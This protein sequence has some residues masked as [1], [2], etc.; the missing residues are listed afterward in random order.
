MRKNLLISLALIL[1]VN[2]HGQIFKS[3]DT[4]K[5]AGYSS[6]RNYDERLMTP[7]EPFR[8]LRANDDKLPEVVNNGKARWFPPIFAQVGGSCGASSRIGYMLTY[9]WN[10]FNQS[11]A[12]LEENQ[13]PPHFQYPFTYNGPAKDAIAISV[14]YPSGKHF[15]GC[16]TS[17]IYGFSEWKSDDFGWMQGYENWYN[18]MFHRISR[19]ANF[20]ESSLTESGAKAIKRWLFNHNGDTNWPTITDENGTHIVGGVAGLGCGINGS[21]LASIANT[22][23]NEKAGVVGLKYMKHWRIGRADHAITLVGYDDRIEFDLDA[24]GVYGEESNYLKM[25]EKGAW[26]CANSWGS[27]WGDKGFFYVPYALAGGVSQEVKYTPKGSSKELTIYTSNGGWWPEVYYLKTNYRPLRTMKVK[28]TYSKRSEISVSV[29]ATQDISS[30]K[31]SVREVFP[32]INYTGDGIA[33]NRDAETPLLGRW[34]DNKMHHEAMEFGIDLT[35]LTENF[36]MSKAIKYFLIIDTKNSANGVGEIELA[37]IMDYTFNKLGIE[38]PAQEKNVSI[39]TKG[40]QTVISIIVRGEALNAPSNLIL[41]NNSLHWTAPLATAYKPVSYV[42]YENNKEIARTTDTSYTLSEAK[43]VYTVKAEYRLGEESSLSSASNNVGGEILSKSEALDNDVINFRNS[44]VRIPNVCS[45][46]HSQF[47]LEFWLKPSSRKNWN[48]QIGNGWGSFLFHLN[49]DGHLT[50][51]WANGANRLDTRA[52]LI[53]PNKWYHIAIVVDGA[54]MKLYVNGTLEKS[55][56]SS[57]YS[58]FPTLSKGLEIGFAVARKWAMSGLMDEIR[59]WDT[60]RTKQEIDENKARPIVRPKLMKHLLAYY[61]MDTIELDGKTYLKDWAKGNHASFINNHYS[62]ENDAQK[63]FGWTDKAIVGEILMPN[64][65]YQGIPVGVDVQTSEDIKEFE[66][67]SSDLSPKK[68]KLRQATLVFNKVGKTSI[69]LKLTDVEGKTLLLNKELDVLA[70]PEPTAEF[71]LSTLSVKGADRISFHA[72]NEAPACSYEWSM[73]EADVTSAT[74]RSASATYGSLGKK[75]VT[76]TVTDAQGKV[77]KLSKT[78]TVEATAPMIDF[79]QSKKIIYKGESVTFTDKSNYLPTEW[80]WSLISENNYTSS[81]VQNPSF[82]LDKAGVYKLM[83]TAK[84]DEGATSHTAPR[85]LIVCASKSYNGLSFRSQGG[86]APQTM[87]TKAL[88]DV[89][90]VWTMDYWFMP[91]KLESGSNGIYGSSDNFAITSDVFGAVT[92]KIGTKRYATPNH[93]YVNNEWHHYAIQLTNDFVI[94]YK[95]GVEF[96]RRGYRGGFIPS[97]LNQIRLGGKAQVDGVF[98]E[99]RFWTSKLSLADLRAYATHQLEGDELKN[100]REQKGLKLYY[101]FN[102]SSGLEV[103]D[104]SGN[105]NNAVRANVGPDGDAWRDS[106]GV[107]ALDFSLPELDEGKLLDRTSYRILTCSDEEMDKSIEPAD[108]VLDGDVKT[109][110]HSRYGKDRKS[111]PHSLTI[112][113]AN[114]DVITAIKIFNNRGRNYRA[115]LLTIEESANGYDWKV[116]EEERYLLDKSIQILTLE[117]PIKEAYFRLTFKNTNTNASFLFIN[118]ITFYGEAE[119]LKTKEVPLTYISCSDEELDKEAGAGRNAF[120]KNEQTLWHSLYG[121]KPRAYAHSITFENKNKEAIALFRIKQKEGKAYSAGKMNIFVS[122]DG[123]NFKFLAHNVRLPYQSEALV[124]LEKVAKAKYIQLEFLN[125]QEHKGDFLAI[126]EISAYTYEGQKLTAIPSLKQELVRC[127]PNPATDYVVIEGLRLGEYLAL[128]NLSGV[129]LK[130][131]RTEQA[132]AVTLDLQG[133]ARGFYIL[134]SEQKVFKLEV[135]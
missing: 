134:R 5:Y 124:C 101:Q 80:R 114:K 26:I 31:A 53:S 25:N 99:F 83:I 75:T 38:T 73:P 49:A 96:A 8:G 47:T 21:Q 55:L 87:T 20:P 12:S 86:N 28:M 40:K 108:Y 106:S 50:A 67:S 84:N 13:F 98:D 19:T 116:V 132:G 104:A 79:S 59:L 29:G 115:D 34:A 48:Q 82:K 127:Y 97:Y 74:T 15:G 105:A 45:D 113:R 125:N 77:Y 123:K 56:T 122:N 7:N 51:G 70:S 95:D 6:E 35:S 64:K 121:D 131:F 4:T 78:F 60:A 39:Q 32:Y 44:G 22:P 119:A 24:N 76:L 62:A 54:E 72:L 92:L 2:L 68:V 90:V 65:V 66:W 103:L 100:A 43:G 16:N 11:N 112:L 129:L 133:L 71:S 37:S 9:E 111:Y 94:F 58:G 3:V 17:N 128:Y 52:N 117:R 118:E 61:K 14:G 135:R 41:N 27:S 18:A 63:T 110:W 10:A 30:D 42:I 102:Q 85:A 91:S 46:V 69:T 23:T 1:G 88:G 130:S 126:K 36:D 89:G 120:D 33:D 107:F 81:R 57:G 109:S 93:Y